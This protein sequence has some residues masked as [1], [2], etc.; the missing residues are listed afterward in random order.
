MDEPV[1]TKFCVCGRVID[2]ITA[3]FYQNR[4]RAFAIS[5]T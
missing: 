2:V 1:V 5:Y 4:L 3:K